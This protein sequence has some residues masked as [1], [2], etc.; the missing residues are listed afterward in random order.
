MSV[1]VLVRQTLNKINFGL[2][3]YKGRGGSMN[4][5]GWEKGVCCFTRG[6]S[7]KIGLGSTFL[8]VQFTDGPSR[9]GGLFYSRSILENGLWSVG[10]CF[11]VFHFSK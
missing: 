5:R 10:I 8:M 6:L 3:G 11:S 4:L 1:F 7:F 9:G 2:R